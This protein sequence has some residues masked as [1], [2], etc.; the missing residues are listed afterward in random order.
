MPSALLA[1]HRWLDSWVGIGAIER[2]MY[3]QGYD[4][5]LTRYANEE[6]RAT[7]YNSGKEHSPTSATGSASEISGTALVVTFPDRSERASGSVGA[8]GTRYER[9]PQLDGA[10][11]ARSALG[12]VLAG[13]KAWW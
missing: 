9:A 3:R 8:A 1:L 6:W 2:G 11:A 13:F 7:F 4:L 10:A 12:T 5:L